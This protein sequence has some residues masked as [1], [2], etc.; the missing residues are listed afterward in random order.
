VAF[1]GKQKALNDVTRRLEALLVRWS[2]PENANGQ[3]ISDT[4]YQNLKTNLLKE[5]ADVESNL[6]KQG[7][8]LED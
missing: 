3:L 2:S 5:K 4:E 7:K 6:Q 8:A 1:E